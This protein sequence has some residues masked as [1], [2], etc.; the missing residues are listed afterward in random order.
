[1]RTVGGFDDFFALKARRQGLT[2][3]STRGAGKVGVSAGGRLWHVDHVGVAAV[4]GGG[5]CGVVGGTCSAEAAAAHGW[6]TWVI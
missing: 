4:R 3:D 6:R 1:M 5:V 2:A